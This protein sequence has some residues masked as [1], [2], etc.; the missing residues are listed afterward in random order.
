[1]RRGAGDGSVCEMVIRHELQ[2][3]ETMRQTLA[4]A[5]LLPAGEPQACEPLVPTR[6]KWIAGA[7]GSIRDGR[8]SRRVR[9]RQRASAPHGLSARV[10]NR[11]P[12][13]DECELGTLQRRH[14][15]GSSRRTGLPCELVRGG[16]VRQGLRRATAKRGRVGE[17]RHLR[18][19]RGCGTSVGVDR[20][21]LRWLP[22]ICGAPLPGVLGSVLRRHLPRAPRRLVGDQS[23]REDADVPQL[24]PAPAPP[25]LRRR[26]PGAGVS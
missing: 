7:G 5:G 21:P 8:A 11:A 22:G 18:A 25:D 19:A 17:G 2:H 20:Q 1:M 16:G 14:V 3:T 4:I 12:S 24:G 9:L 15:E 23:A 13:R 26:A 10:S 6:T